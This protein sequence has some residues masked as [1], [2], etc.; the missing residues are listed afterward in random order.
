MESAAHLQPMSGKGGH[1]GVVAGFGGEGELDGDRFTGLDEGGVGDD[2][3]GLL[4]DVVFLDG[5][6]VGDHGGGE[7]A[8]RVDFAGFDEDEVVGLLEGAV[9][10]VE[11]EGDAGTG[12]AAEFGFVEGEGD[13]GVRSQF[14]RGRSEFLRAEGGEQGGEGDQSQQGRRCHEASERGKL[15]LEITG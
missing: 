13:L 3:G 14:H 11:G 12:F 1:E 15:P 10:V 8:D 5:L 7:G 9:D 4:R 2:V 6:G